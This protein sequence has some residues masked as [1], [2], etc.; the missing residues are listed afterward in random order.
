MENYEFEKRTAL[1][2]KII[3][4]FGTVQA[5]AAAFD[6]TYTHMLNLINGKTGWSLDGARK[7]CV[8]LGIKDDASELKRI[9][10][11]FDD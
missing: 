9:F 6:C 8:L 5:F 4:K 3:E 7:A 11:S 2:G 1:H 10:F